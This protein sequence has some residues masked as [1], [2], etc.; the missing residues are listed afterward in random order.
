MNLVYK[1]QVDKIIKHIEKIIKLTQPRVRGLVRKVTR[2]LACFSWSSES[3]L[4]PYA[5]TRNHWTTVT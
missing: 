5:L 2:N 3:N 4:R 1:L